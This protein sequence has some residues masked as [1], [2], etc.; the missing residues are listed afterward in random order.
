MKTQIAI[1]VDDR[2]YDEYWLKGYYV[3]NCKDPRCFIIKRIMY[4]DREALLRMMNNA[5]NKI[6]Q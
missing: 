6:L 4:E 2:K 1:V 5:D 3:I